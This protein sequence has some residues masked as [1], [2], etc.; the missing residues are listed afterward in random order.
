M[1]RV[2]TIKIF[3]QDFSI[4]TEADESRIQ[5]LAEYLQQRFD[6][7]KVAARHASRP[8][9]MALTLLDVANDFFEV[10]DLLSE[11]KSEVESRSNQ[12]I[13][14]IESISPMEV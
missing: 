4:K 6:K 10:R 5:E 9:Q 11:V 14:R 12:M 2:Y 8:D 1:K 13:S 7:I 3:D